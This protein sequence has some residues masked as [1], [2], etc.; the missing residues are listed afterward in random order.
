MGHRVVHDDELFAHFITFSCFRRRRILDLDWPKRIV[1]GSL[2]AQMERE[3][4][5]CVG[6]VVM[7]D[8]VHLVVSFSSVGKLSHFMQGWK[9]RP[10]YEIRRFLRRSHSKYEAWIRDDEP[11][12]QARYY[13]FEIYTQD[14]LLGK[15]K[16]MH[17]NPVRAGLVANTVDWPWSSARHYELGQTVGVPIGSAG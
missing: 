12:W 9:R 4:A 1:L 2:V 8:H 13:S 11:I 5:T 6:F 16:Y 3:S 7:P 17:E 10:S 15:L 14:K